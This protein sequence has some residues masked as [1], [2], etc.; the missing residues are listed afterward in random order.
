MAPKLL[1]TCDVTQLGCELLD[2]SRLVNRPT[3]G[4]M[5]PEL[6]DEETAAL[7]RLLSKD[8]RRRPLP[9]VAPNSDAEGDP[10]QD[11]AGAGAPAAAATEAL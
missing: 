5:I 8:N 11:P 4:G 7:E 9:A 2:S 1:L 6:S 3:Y 10:W